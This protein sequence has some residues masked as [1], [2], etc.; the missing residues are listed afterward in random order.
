M[1]LFPEF[2]SYEFLMERKAPM[3]IASWE[4]LYQQNPIITGGGIFPVD[5]VKLSQ[6]MPP[7]DKIKKVVRYWDKAGTTDDGA[8]TAGVL[9]ISVEDGGWFIPDVVRGQW[10]AFERENIIKATAERDAERYGRMKVVI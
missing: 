9:M 4:S 6:A 7:D 2:K 3:T 8:Y 5:R 1:P 10:G